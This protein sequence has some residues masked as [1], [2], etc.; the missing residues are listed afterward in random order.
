V[1][2]AAALAKAVVVVAQERTERAR[3]SAAHEQVMARIAAR[4]RV[5]TTAVTSQIAERQQV[6][7][8]LASLAHDPAAVSDPASLSTVVGAMVDLA[9]SSPFDGIRDMAAALD[10]NAGGPVIEGELA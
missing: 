3:I 6:F 8:Q 1:E 2:V 5:V 4:E 9:R 10:D 7:T